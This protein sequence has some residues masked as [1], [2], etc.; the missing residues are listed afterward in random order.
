[1]FLFIVVR[2][3][4]NENQLFKD[5]CQ[6]KKNTQYLHILAQQTNKLRLEESL[7]TLS[8]YV[9]GSQV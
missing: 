6:I 8:P 5:F 4:R 1:M 9:Y 2:D 7:Q 3:N